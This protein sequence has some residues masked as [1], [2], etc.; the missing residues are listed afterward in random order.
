MAFSNPSLLCLSCIVFQFHFLRT[1][2]F[3]SE[4]RCFLFII[5]I[6]FFLLFYPLYSV[7]LT[8][9]LLSKILIDFIY[10]PRSNLFIFLILRLYIFFFLVFDSLFYNLTP[11]FIKTLFLHLYSITY[12]FIHLISIPKTNIPCY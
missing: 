1:V 10:P 2:S 11:A 7:F 8:I 3:I 6:I 12:N 5:I 4:T 9:L